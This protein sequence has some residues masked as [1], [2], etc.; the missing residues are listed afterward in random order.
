MHQ[1]GDIVAEAASSIGA[2]GISS[3]IYWLSAPQPILLDFIL[4]FIGSLLPSK[5]GVR[6]G[7]L[8]GLMMGPAIATV[9]RLNN[10]DTSLPPGFLHTLA[11]LGS[12]GKFIFGIAG[13]IIGAIAFIT[14]HRGL[15]F[16]RF[17]ANSLAAGGTGFIIGVVWGILLVVMG[18]GNRHPPPGLMPNLIGMAITDVIICTI[19]GVVI[20]LPLA[21]VDLI[22]RK[23]QYD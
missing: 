8:A 2:F 15:Y 12:N 4:L 20:G 9:S 11:F 7:T 21:V 6:L 17:L 3:G 19:A 23:N 13:G 18:M 22:S 10:W 5:I 1:K 16:P 14:F